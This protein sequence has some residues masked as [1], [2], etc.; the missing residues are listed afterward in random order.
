ME[1]N[2]PS[3]SWLKRCLVVFLAGGLLGFGLLWTPASPAVFGF[4]SYC[5]VCGLEQRTLRNQLPLSEVTLFERSVESPTLY[6]GAYYAGGGPSHA[7]DFV[8]AA[9]SG[10]GVKCAIGDGRQQQR[11][12]QDP[13][14]AASLRFVLGQ[15]GAPELQRVYAQHLLVLRSPP[16]SSRARRRRS[17]AGARLRSRRSTSRSWASSSKARPTSSSWRSRRDFKPSSSSAPDAD[18]RGTRVPPRPRVAL[19]ILRQG[20]RDKP[21][22]AS[23]FEARA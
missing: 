15:V 19:S 5:R 23:T 10:N 12:A 13:D 3:S 6:S 11:G 9:G 22:S 1:P 4:S 18:P 21:A 14:R 20:L 7:H 2:V 17:T 8:F 16:S